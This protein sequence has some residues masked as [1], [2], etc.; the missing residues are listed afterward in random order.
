MEITEQA[1]EEALVLT[2]SGRLNL[3]SRKTFQAVMKSVEQTTATNHVVVDIHGVEYL[4]SVA[5]GVLALSQAN[6]SMIGI[7]MSLVGPQGPVREVLE[8][9]NI[10]KLIPIYAT[11]EEAIGLS[12]G[13]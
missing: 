8:I 2:I 3:Y 10:P 9:S 6:F 13:T 5:L 7:E 12:V 1:R 4:D 11:V